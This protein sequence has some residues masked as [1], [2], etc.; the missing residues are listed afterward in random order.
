MSEESIE[1][2]SSQ[3]EPIS[4]FFER[5]HEEDETRSTPDTSSAETQQIEQFQEVSVLDKKKEENK[6]RYQ[7]SKEKLLALRANQVHG[8]ELV[9]F[10]INNKLRKITIQSEKEYLNL[11]EDLIGTLKDN[12]M[13]SDYLLTP[14]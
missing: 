10:N 11:I 8:C 3:E 12:E 14:Y 9:L 1:E 13:L 5:K 7:R 4:T 2:K 6:R